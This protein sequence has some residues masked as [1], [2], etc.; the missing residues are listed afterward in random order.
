MKV[1]I[2]VFAFLIV[3]TVSLVADENISL[4]QISPNGLTG[5]TR[6]A[7]RHSS[8]AWMNRFLDIKTKNG[9]VKEFEAEYAFIIGW[10]FSRSDTCVVIQSQNA[11]GPYYWQ[12]F[13]ISTGK[14]LDEFYRSKA[15]KFPE[16]AI[17]FTKQNKS[18]EQGAAAN[19]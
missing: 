2:S 13:D 12:I 19:P 10:A 17:D 3:T 7:S 9:D 5:W 16:W 4:K 18:A 15:D 14:L 11:H 1:I 6:A 8:G